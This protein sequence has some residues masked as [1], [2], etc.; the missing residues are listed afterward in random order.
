MECVWL[1]T[2]AVDSRGRTR[3]RLFLLLLESCG[4]APRR[5]FFAKEGDLSAD[6]NNKQLTFVR[7]AASRRS[8]TVLPNACR[9]PEIQFKKIGGN[10]ARTRKTG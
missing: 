5:S 6:M 8:L 4:H 10:D 1:A 2:V 3:P 9:A 7:L